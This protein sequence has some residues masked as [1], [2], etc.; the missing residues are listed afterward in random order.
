VF[1]SGNKAFA[2]PKLNG[3]AIRKPFGFADCIVVVSTN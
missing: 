2:A 3:A 1:Q